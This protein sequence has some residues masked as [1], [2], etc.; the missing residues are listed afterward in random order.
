MTAVGAV[1]WTTVS[2][3]LDALRKSMAEDPLVHR[4]LSAAREVTP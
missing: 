1:E 4:Q 2:E 3:R